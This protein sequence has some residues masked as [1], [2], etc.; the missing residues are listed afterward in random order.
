MEAYDF[1][2]YGTASALV[3]N[4]VFF[5]GFDPLV[6]T[7]LA[8]G[9]F[10]VGAVMRPLGGIVCGHFGDRIGRK[11]M[12]VWTVVAMGTATVL[13]GLIPSYGQIGV[14]APVI[15]T[16]LRGVQ[17]FAVGG[18]WAGGALV[19]VEHAP[20]KRSAVFASFTQMG[21]P[22]ALFLSTGTFALLI[23]LPKDQF[24]SWGWRLPFI[25]SAILIILGLVVRLKLLEPPVFVAAMAAGK[26]AS[27]PVV[28]VF[29]KHFKSLLISSGLILCTTV[30]FYV[31][32]VFV[33]SYATQGLTL[34][35]QTILNAVLIASG[36]ELA[37]LPLFGLLADRVGVKSIALFGAIWTGAFSFPFFWLVNAGTPL[38]VG[39]AI[40][41][42]MVGISALFSV[43]PSYLA[44]LFP[45]QVRYTGLSIAYGITA[46]LIAGLT[47]LLASALFIWAKSAWPIALY[48][49]VV[50]AIT[51]VAIVA[52]PGAWRA[53][54][55]NQT[56]SSLDDLDVSVLAPGFTRSI[57]E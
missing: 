37:M 8:F 25:A 16:I 44:G 5:P 26:K 29:A 47:P 23:Q 42:A 40:S 39:L 46:G 53:K 45:T 32:A 38:D 43:L 54:S 9:T 14:A 50:A 1:Y 35:R 33:V 41:L 21:S 6:G 24:L 55:G 11:T 19:A 27:F 31:E 12:L 56:G 13:I 2:I 52:S 30:A 15:L 3:F 22:V 28:E 51:V 17:G 49:S 36:F 48:L 7:L 18:E 34:P 57:A 4:V 10:G 20:A